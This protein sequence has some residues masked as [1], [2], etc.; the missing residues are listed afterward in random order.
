RRRCLLQIL[1]VPGG[2]AFVAVA[3]VAR[4]LDAVKL[5]RVD[6]EL[7][8]NAETSQSLIHLLAALNGHV[9]VALAAEEE[10]RRLDAVGVKERVRDFHV[11]LP[12]LR[13]PRR[14]DLVIVLRDVLIRAVE[15]DR[16]S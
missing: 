13:V 3:Y 15:G 14:A 9:E 6:D 8:V 11:G 12:I 4:T 7:R 10:R 16:E 1:V 5:V 2:V